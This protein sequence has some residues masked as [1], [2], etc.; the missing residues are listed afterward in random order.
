MLQYYVSIKNI[1]PGAVD[2]NCN[3][4]YSGGRDVEYSGLGQTTQKVNETPPHLKK[5]AECARRQEV[6]G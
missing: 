1:S 3:P 4:S 5:K 6:G 2:H